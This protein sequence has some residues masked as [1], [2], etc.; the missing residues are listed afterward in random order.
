MR[1][2]SVSKREAEQTFVLTSTD[3]TTGLTTR[4]L[5]GN[6]YSSHSLLGDFLD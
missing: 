2:L 3:A 5:G 6:Y 4:Y 1:P